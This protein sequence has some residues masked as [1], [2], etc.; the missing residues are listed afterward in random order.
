M[1]LVDLNNL[2]F[3]AQ[4]GGQKL[5][6][7]DLET[8][9]IYGFLRM[10]RVI[11][12]EFG[13]RLICLHDG[14]SWRHEAFSDYKANRKSDPKLI[15][16]RD[17]WKASKPWVVRL[18]RL[19][20]VDQI[21]SA[22]MEADDLAARMRRVARAQGKEVTL[23]SGDADWVQ[24]VGPGCQLFNPGQEKLIRESNFT[25]KTGLPHPKAIAEVKSLMGDAS[26]CVPGVGGIGEKTA[27]AILNTYGSVAG[28]TNAMM[29]DPEARKKADKRA[30][31]LLDETDKQDAFERNMRLIW[32]DHP[33]VPAPVKPSIV[34]GTMDKAAFATFCEELAFHSIL[35]E[36]D[37]WLL[38][39]QGD[40]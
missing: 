35:R 21:A 9:G 27:T 16:A 13:G 38:P 10:L 24:L 36:L 6:A 28:F 23:V 4:L 33:G 32:L 8:T 17:R 39:F 15:E 26:D 34:K 30:L 2:G 3:R 31:K 11:R 29:A 7:G 20:N 14:R 19:I 12:A 22:N 5:T 25:E 18:L 40:K 37:S 1:V